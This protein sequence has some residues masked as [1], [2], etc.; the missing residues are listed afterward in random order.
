MVEG[1]IGTPKK[2]IIPAVINKGNKLGTKE[3][4][5]ILNDLNIHAINNAIRTIARDKESTRL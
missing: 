4:K 5:I 2:P 3:I 1:F